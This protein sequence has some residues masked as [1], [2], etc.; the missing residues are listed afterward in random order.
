MWRKIARW[1][2]G[3]DEEA[4]RLLQHPVTA[5]LFLDIRMPGLS[6][7]EVAE[8]IGKRAHVV[9][10]TAYDQYAVDAFDAG[11]VDYLLKP[12]QA[13][14]LQRALARLRDQFGAQPADMVH[15]LQSLRAALPAPR[16]KKLKCIGASVEKVPVSRTLTHLFRD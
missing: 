5:A 13:E 3:F 15:L 10:V 16:R 8:R 1:Y 14:R 9:F 2:G 12:V 7:L 4:L 11:A 6:G